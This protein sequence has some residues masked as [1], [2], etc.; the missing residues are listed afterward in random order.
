M[1]Q[2]PIYYIK[3][4]K[5]FFVDATKGRA[6]LWKAF[7]IPFLLIIAITTIYQQI[8]VGDDY[9]KFIGSPAYVIFRFCITPLVF[10]WSW[11]VVRCSKNTSRAVW[12]WSARLYAFFIV[13]KTLVFIYKH[14]A[15]K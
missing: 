7:F 2:E 14:I 11:V 12:T 15:F 13:F 6:K 10:W 9:E 4:S 8:M 5:Q 3:A 1:L